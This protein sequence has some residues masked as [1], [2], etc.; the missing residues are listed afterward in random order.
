MKEEEE[1]RKLKELLE[2]RKKKTT[3]QIELDP[4]ERDFEEVA[5]DPREDAMLSNNPVP[6][7]S[8]FSRKFAEIIENDDQVFED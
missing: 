6:L 2:T 1:E 4:I 8:D 7:F 3:A 5:Y